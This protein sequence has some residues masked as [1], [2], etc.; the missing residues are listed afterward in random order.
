MIGAIVQARIGS[1]RLP[2]KVMKE[3]LGRPLLFYL[4]ERLKQSELI[5][6]IIVATTNKNTDQKISDYVKSLGLGT[7]C[8]SEDDVLD[9]YY[10]AAR[11][12]KI[13]IIVR[14]TSDCPLIEPKVTD[15]VIQY[16]LEHQEYDLVR[17]GPTYPEG[18]DTEV[19]PFKTLQTA[20]REARLKSEREHVTP[21]ICK[22]DNRFKVKTL[23]FYQDLSCLRMAV[24]EEVDFKVVKSILENLYK[25]GE[26]FYLEDLLR[27]YRENPD[28]FNLNKKVIRNEGYLKILAEESGIGGDDYS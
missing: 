26:I 6:K 23:V 17:S 5:E 12:Y 16:Y 20:W 24:D 21:Y 19:F 7:F 2:G 15:E 9:R 10:Q 11:K 18:F 14:I 3:V 4:T 25:E 8:G 1:T 22:N 28:I 27:F 13:D